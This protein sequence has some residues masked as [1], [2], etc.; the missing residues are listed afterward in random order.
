VVHENL[1]LV[2]SPLAVSSP[3][4]ERVDYRLKLFVMDLVVDFRVGIFLSGMPLGVV[5]FPCPF[6][7]G[8]LLLRSPRRQSR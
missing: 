7:K 6:V 3:V 1:D 4:F 2:H 8:L 5:D